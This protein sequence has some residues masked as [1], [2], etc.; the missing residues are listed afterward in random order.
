MSKDSFKIKVIDLIGEILEIEKEEIEE[1]ADF[2]IDFN[3]SSLEMTDLVLRLNQALKINL[4]QEEVEKIK[5]VGDLLNLIEVQ[6][7]EI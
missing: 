5:T 3:L 6:S 7:D 4:P 2:F 1:D